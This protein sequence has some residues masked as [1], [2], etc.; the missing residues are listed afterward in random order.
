MNIETLFI[1]GASGHAKVVVDALRCKYGPDIDL[2][3]TDDNSALKGKF[4][5]GIPIVGR[6][7][8]AAVHGDPFHVA[9][10]N[11][12]IRMRI[13]HDCLRSG[14]AYKSVIHPR[15]IVADSASVGEGCLVA[16]GAII[17]PGAAISRGCIINHGAV[18]DHDCWLGSFC[19][20]APN[21]T[22]A[23]GIKLGDRV[24]VGA[25]V[26]ILPGVTI[27][28]DC[29]IGAGSVVPHDLRESGTYLGVPARRI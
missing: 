11:N 20:V 3:L 17:A 12:A 22:L 8:V 4:L 26:N 5:M 18:V 24:L 13:A 19:H 2:L 23:G 27:A 28:D 21:A 16:A 6:D 1:F 25:G 9:I 15:A 7:A 10:G 14:M 29:V